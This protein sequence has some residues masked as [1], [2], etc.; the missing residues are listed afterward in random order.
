MERLPFHF[1]KYETGRVPVDRSAHREN[2][3]PKGHEEVGLESFRRLPRFEDLN[4][5]GRA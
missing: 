2:P 5:S 3:V 1:M 4:K